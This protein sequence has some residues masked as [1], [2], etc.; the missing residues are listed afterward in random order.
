MTFVAKVQLAGLSPSDLLVQSCHGHLDSHGDVH[1]PST[2]T[3]EPQG[4]IQDGWQTYE[5]KIVCDAAGRYGYR[6]RVLPSHANL[7]TPL[8]PNLVTWG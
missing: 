5:G 4:A 3:L 6:L 8:E 1:E 2:L 7:A